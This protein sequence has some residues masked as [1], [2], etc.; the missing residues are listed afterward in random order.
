MNAQ[1]EQ[2]SSPAVAALSDKQLR[3]THIAAAVGCSAGFGVFPLRRDRDPPLEPGGDLA[4][5]WPG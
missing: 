2:P 1:A 4:E 3:Q 5:P